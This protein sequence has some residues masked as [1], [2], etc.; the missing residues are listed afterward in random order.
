MAPDRLDLSPLVV[1]GVKIGQP[2]PVKVK[3]SGFTVHGTAV[4]T[5][6]SEK[7][8]AFEIHIRDRVFGKKIEK[9]VTVQVARKADGSYH[10]SKFEADTGI[11]EE[12]DTTRVE[13]EGRS[14][15]LFVPDQKRHRDAQIRFTNPGDGSFKIRGE[16]FTAEFRV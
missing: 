12:G 9:D 10:V 14:M 13:R 3:K 7:A 6:M 15:V 8:S 1:E 5:E 4:V 11:K 2:M 16:D